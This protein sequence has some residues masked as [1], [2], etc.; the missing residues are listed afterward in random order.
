MRW[1]HQNEARPVNISHLNHHP[2]TQ[3]R[4][5]GCWEWG[6]W[7]H[8]AK[9]MMVGWGWGWGWGCI[10]HI[11]VCL[12]TCRA[13][14]VPT[15]LGGCG[16]DPWHLVAGKNGANLFFFFHCEKTWGE[17]KASLHTGL[18]CPGR[19]W[20][21]TTSHNRRTEETGRARFCCQVCL[22]LS[23]SHNAS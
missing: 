9:A 6:R 2:V 16:T 11:I 21:Q 14:G 4:P 19:K 20:K 8:F 5:W 15:A 3:Y 7:V 12:G 1:V 10:V 22:P 23:R 13:G 18:I 17:D